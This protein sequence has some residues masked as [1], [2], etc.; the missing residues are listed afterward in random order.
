MAVSPADCYVTI[1][2]QSSTTGTC[3]LEKLL[4]TNACMYI[5]TVDACSSV[6]LDSLERLYNPDGSGNVTGEI[7][8]I[9]IS[10]IWK[11]A[12]EYSFDCTNEGRAAYRQA[13]IWRS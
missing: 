1:L 8:Q 13:W 9:C 12:C 4:T 10:E 3:M 7:L 5:T 6:E 2:E 11:S